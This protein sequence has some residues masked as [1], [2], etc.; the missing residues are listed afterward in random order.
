MLK[1]RPRI[2][3]AKSIKVIARMTAAAARC[4]FVSALV[5]LSRAVRGFALWPI[6]FCIAISLI[7]SFLG[8]RDPFAA[9]EQIEYVAQAIR[10]IQ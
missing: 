7:Q 1:V 5:C 2:N 6:L 8:R 10:E 9:A 4:S 3:G